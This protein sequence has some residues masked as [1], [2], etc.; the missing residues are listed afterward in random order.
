MLMSK[1]FANSIKFI[2]IDL[3]NMPK[4]EFEELLKMHEDGE[5][6]TFLNDLRKFGKYLSDK[7]DEYSYKALTKEKE[8][9]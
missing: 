1:S 3:Y 2:A 6:A 8:K 5:V 9:K 4:Q 7:N